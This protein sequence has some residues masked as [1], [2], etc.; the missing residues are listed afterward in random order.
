M[1]LPRASVVRQLRAEGSASTGTL[2]ITHGLPTVLALGLIFAT[3]APAQTAT[4]RKAST[5]RANPKSPPTGSSEERLEKD[6]QALLAKDDDAAEAVERLLKEN[7]A[8][9]SKG[10]GLEKI[11]LQARIDEQFT[12]VRKAYEEFLRR[13]PKHARARIAFG[14]FLN[15]RGE[16][17]YAMEQWEKARIQDPSIPAVWNNLANYYGHRGPVK[18]AFEYYAKAIELDPK[19]AV[20]YQNFGTTV[21]L[22][23]KDAR[24]HFSLSEQQV[25]DKALA[26]YRQAVKLAPADFALAT[27]VAQTYYGIQPLRAKEALAAWAAALKLAADD[28]QREGIL[29]HLARVH[30]LAGEYAVAREH[31]AKVRHAGYDALKERLSR[32]IDEHE[33]RGK[34]TAA[35]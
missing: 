34:G 17:E 3:S 9:E 33:K 29:L 13:H 18:R 24:E 20:Y 32:S 16:E 14:S 27:D 35:E 19:E 15:E 5:E 23:R 25:F 6:Y 12:P 26:L 22:F 30:M 1:S 11:T 4:P 21:F 10:A 28:I 8:F 2:R 31:V 7:T